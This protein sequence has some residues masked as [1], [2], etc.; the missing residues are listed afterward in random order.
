MDNFRHKFPITPHANLAQALANYNG[1]PRAQQVGQSGGSLAER[2]GFSPRQA[3]RQ[4]PNYSSGGLIGS[5]SPGKPVPRANI[6]MSQMQNL[7]LFFNKPAAQGK[8]PSYTSN[9][10][11]KGY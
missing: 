1:R 11:F 8:R 9:P 3:P 6:D 4:R 2:F 10:R 7:P 5:M